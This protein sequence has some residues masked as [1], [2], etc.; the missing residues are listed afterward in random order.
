MKGDLLKSKQHYELLDGLRGVAAIAVV[1]F[2]F[3]EIIY[4]D[5]SKNFIGHGFL[6]VDFFFCLS[7]FV[8]AYAYDSRIGSMGL[9]EFFTTRVI[10]LHPLVVLGSIL[11]LVSF[12]IDPF[13]SL[14]AGYGFGKLTLIFVSSVLMIPYPV[15]AERYFNLFNLNAPAWSLF[16]E[17]VAN[18]VYGVVLWRLSRRVLV[19]LLIIAAVGILFVSHSAG[20]LMGGWSGGTFWQGGAR[21]AYSF[22]A[23]MLVYRY[24]LIIRNKLG[25]LG[26][27]VM[28][29]AAL[30]MPYTTWNWLAEAL[31]VIVYFP[32]LI[33]LGAGAGLHAGTRGICNFSGKISYPLYMTHYMVMFS[34][35]NYYNQYKPGTGLLVWIVVTGLVVL[36]AF[37]WLVMVL[38]DMP[39]RKY[40]TRLRRKV[41]YPAG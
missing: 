34:F 33:A 17:Y 20:N 27:S 24:N 25:F 12:L 26:L 32:F 37:A 28:L 5:Y 1:T 31:V 39:V 38:Y 41:L 9:K 14:P 19:G 10:R 40:L 30:M 18:I 35:A 16:W 4:S 8:I 22:L 21:I 29:L 7:G 2:H 23:G 6:A 15:V 36:T 3:M 11:G 13:M